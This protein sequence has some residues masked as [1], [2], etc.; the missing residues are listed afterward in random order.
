MRDYKRSA[1]SRASSGASSREEALDPRRGRTFQPPLD[2][3]CKPSVLPSLENT[4]RASRVALGGGFLCSEY[5]LQP[6]TVPTTRVFSL[7]R[8]FLVRAGRLVVGQAT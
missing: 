5:L 7:G 3:S 4:R 1:A 8:A 6:E 2:A